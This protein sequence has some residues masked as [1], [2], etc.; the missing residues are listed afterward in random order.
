MEVATALGAV[1]GAGDGL[2]AEL[3]TEGENSNILALLGGTTGPGVS[4]PLES[5]SASRGRGADECGIMRGARDFG[6]RGCLCTGISSGFG[7]ALRLLLA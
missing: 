1:A 3:L 6:D 5:C 4:S 2:D 7:V